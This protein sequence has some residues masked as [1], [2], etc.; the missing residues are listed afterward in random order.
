MADTTLTVAVD[1]REAI[2]SIEGLKSAISGLVG[3]AA[4]KSLMDFSDGIT[5]LNNKLL[6]LSGSSETAATQFS[7][8][9][10]IAM[11]ARAPL[12]ETGD[13]F[14][15]L[16]QAGK[17][18]GMSNREA[19]D[20]TSTLTK[21]FSMAGM[22]AGELSGALLQIG[23]GMSAGVFQGDELRTILESSRPVS[24]A[25]AAA[26]GVTVGELKKLGSQGVITADVFRAAM[27][28]AKDGVDEAFGKSI[29]TFA[30]AFTTLGTAS[31]VAFNEFEKNTETGKNLATSINGL[32]LQL[33]ILAENVDKII[34]PLKVLFQVLEF[35]LIFTVIGKAASILR[36]AFTGLVVAWE[37]LTAAFAG[38]RATLVGLEY[39]LSGVSGIFSTL[40]VYVR[41]ADGIFT[42]FAVALAG[43]SQAALAYMGLDAVNK[44]FAD[45]GKKTEEGST[46]SERYAAA[47]KEQRDALDDIEGANKAAAAR[48]EELAKK[49]DMVRL[50]ARQQTDDLKINLDRTRDKLRF[51]AEQ[52]I[53]NGKFT[54]KTKEQIE[55]DTAL[56]DLDYE[57]MDTIRKL[58]QDQ[59]KLNLEF[60]KMKPGAAGRESQQGKEIQQRVGILGNQIKVEEKLYAQQKE[61]LPA[62]IIQLQTAKMLEAARLQDTQ[63]MIKAVEDQIAR[64]QSLGDQ[65][66]S[67]NDQKVDLKFQTGEI[68]KSVLNQQFDKIQEDAR[69]AGL[70]AGRAFAESFGQDELTPEKARELAD[71]LALIKKGYDDIS[72]AQL[73]N[74]EQSRTWSAGWTEAYNK[75]Y[76]DAYNSATNASQ[77]FNTATKGMEDA[78]VKFALTGKLSFTDLANSIIADIM[79]ILVKRVILSS[80]GL[81]GDMF[82]GIFKAGGGSVNS[83]TP[84]VVGDAG[85][86]L[87][88]PTSAGTI[89]PNNK[90]SD[91][92]NSTNVVYNIQAV[93]ASS[94]RSLVARD[95]QFIYN[96]TEVGRKSTPSR[97]FA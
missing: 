10:A 46:A 76:E 96:I 1:T 30:Q 70:S 47:L 71:G 62:Y 79:R 23:Q 8:I 84:Y 63:N 65:L 9:A 40:M 92:G 6:L 43:V 27:K 7:A 22:S 87:F 74:L 42:K 53:V 61:A 90:L 78:L 95:P 14:F 33:F 13:L 58:T 52:I 31:R 24:E 72:A 21:T 64:N 17:E 38:A 26:L 49:M 45:L 97:R 34:G 29:P 16:A 69:K 57:R 2:K 80:M 11:E 5:S 4:V 44:W 51:D 25:L 68:G 89:I 67:I 73:A 48:E 12:K 77:I 81:G 15:K 35:L 88:V 20:I 37:G 85:P 50:A 91:G 19:G 66:K 83:G 54:N 82:G 56:R 36:V 18:L 55:L 60:S 93:D 39:S 59:E 3:V 75:Y 86:E 28:Q 32:G 41:A 94:F